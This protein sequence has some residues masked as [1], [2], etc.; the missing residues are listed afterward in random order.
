[1][2]TWVVA[3]FCTLILYVTVT[4]GILG[5]IDRTPRLRANR[6]K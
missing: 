3:M 2:G 1:L 4:A 6:P 5:R